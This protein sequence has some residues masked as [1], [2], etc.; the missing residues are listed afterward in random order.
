MLKKLTMEEAVNF[1]GLPIPIFELI[2]ENA[3]LCYGDVVGN[4]TNSIVAFSGSAVSKFDAILRYIG[5]DEAVRFKGNANMLLKFASEKL[6]LEGIRGMYI[7][8]NEDAIELA[9]HHEFLCAE[10]FIPVC[11]TGRCL[12]YNLKTMK[13]ADGYKELDKYLEK[14]P[15]TEKLAD[16]NDPLLHRFLVR[17]RDNGLFVAKDSHSPEYSR[18]YKH[19]R[20]IQAAIFIS[21]VREDYVMSQLFWEKGVF[22][23]TVLPSL[24]GG[25]VKELEQLNDDA[26]LELYVYEDIIYNGVINV[27]GCPITETKIFEYYR[28]LR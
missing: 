14:L 8:L 25:C 20:E 6:L 22:S 27:F 11:T 4:K 26:K 16:W 23:K 17:N 5:V 10:H 12:T 24:I 28:P 18:V 21:K 2:I 7:K 1:S 15:K 9:G 13:E 3:C 19:D